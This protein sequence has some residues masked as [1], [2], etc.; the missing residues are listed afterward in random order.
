MSNSAWDLTAG[1]PYTLDFL[2]DGQTQFRIFAK[3]SSAKLIAGQVP[4]SAVNRF[5]KAQ[6]LAVTWNGQSEQFNLGAVERL[7]RSISNCVE[8]MASAGIAGAGD[9]SASSA[10]PTVEHTASRSDHAAI[11]SADPPPDTRQ[12]KPSK[13]AAVSGTGFA[14]SA[15]GHVVTNA[16]VVRHCI[17]DIR[18]NLTGEPATTLRVVSTDEINDLALLQTKASFKELARIRATP[19]RSGDSVVAIGFPLHGLLTTD[20]TVTT[21]IVN[22]LSGILNDTRFLQISAEVQPGNSGGPLLDTSGN[23]V[24]VVSEKLNALRFAKLTGD[25]PQNIN[26]AIKTGAVRDFLDNSVVPYVTAEPRAEL[27]NPEIAEH[28]RAFTMLIWCTAAAEDATKK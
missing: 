15:K 25:L 8:R 7:P 28:A 27:R 16:H 4:E 10:R 5:G 23:R 9:F 26:F 21:G 20:F 11:R 2:F 17:S 12:Q 1:T 24:G 14:V 22:S 19:V 13:P 3:A 6:L 18:G